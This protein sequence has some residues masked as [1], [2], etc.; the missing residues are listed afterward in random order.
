MED[1]DED[2]PPSLRVVS[3]N[4]NARADRQI[5]WAKDEAQRPLSQFAAALLRAMAGNDTEATYLVRRCRPRATG[6]ESQAKA[7]R[8][9]GSHTNEIRSFWPPPCWI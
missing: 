9:T 5:E 3:D 1:D 6:R 2:K 8:A 7:R 4:P